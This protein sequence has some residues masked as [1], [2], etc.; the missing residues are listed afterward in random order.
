MYLFGQGQQVARECPPAKR[1]QR[2]N[3]MI[4][5]NHY[6]WFEK[7]EEAYKYGLTQQVPTAVSK[8][9]A[10]CWALTSV[11]LQKARLL[12]IFSNYRG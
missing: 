3:A 7:I 5:T 12:K 4:A 11:A 2:A 6:G 8:L 1:V 9:Q 10:V